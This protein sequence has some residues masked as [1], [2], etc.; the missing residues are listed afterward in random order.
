M[1]VLITG[2]GSRLGAALLQALSPHYDVLTLDLTGHGHGPGPTYV[3]DPRDR[4]VAA[5]AV[6]GCDAI[7]HLPPLAPAEASPVDVLDAATRG[8]YNLITTAASATR[9]ILI[10]SLRLFERYPMEW[11]VTEQWAPRPT[12]DVED[13]APYLAE[14]TVREVARVAPLKAIALRLGEVVD[15]DDVR[16]RSPD[17]RWLHVEDAVHAV[18]RALVYDVPAPVHHEPTFDP[19][20]TGWWVFHVP[21]AARRLASRWRWRASRP[22]ATFP[23][24][25]SARASP[26]PSPRTPTARPSD[27]PTR[28]VAPRATW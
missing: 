17:A 19:P 16:D 24:T 14:C 26:C 23:R 13:L 4:E 7:V 1:R 15:D 28:R 2:S 12:T 9:F 18:E 27:S 25:I 22:S 5:R 20:A 8:T 11:R 3:G 6:A 10:S 21:G